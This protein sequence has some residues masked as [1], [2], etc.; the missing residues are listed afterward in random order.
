[1]GD[2]QVPAGPQSLAAAGSEYTVVGPN[3][4][5]SDLMITVRTFNAAGD[6][7]TDGDEQN[8]AQGSVTVD[9]VASIAKSA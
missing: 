1:M 7:S 9:F 3:R 4:A 2:A 5:G 8:V 6:S